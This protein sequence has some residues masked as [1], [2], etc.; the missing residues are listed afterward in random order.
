MMHDAHV[1]V[2][3]RLFNCHKR[4]FELLQ[5]AKVRGGDAEHL[6]LVIAKNTLHC[7]LVTRAAVELWQARLTLLAHPLCERVLHNRCWNCAGLC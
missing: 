6:G 4:L 3:V 1:H 7:L 5:L 2:R